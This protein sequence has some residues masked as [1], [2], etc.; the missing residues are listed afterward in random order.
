MNSEWSK[1]EIDACVRTYLWMRDSE[2][3]GYQPVKS[4]A[5]I[6]LRE[7]PLSERS[8][9]SLEYRFQN[10]SAV[11]ADRKEE[12]I[13]GYKPAKN[14]GAETASKIA[15]CIEAYGKVR[16]ARRVN[17]LMNALPKKTIVKAVTELASGKEFSYSD[18]TEYDLLYRGI[19]LP[20]KKVIG[21][22]AFLHYRAPLLSWNFSGGENTPCFKRLEGAGFTIV[23]KADS[24]T[25]NPEWTEFRKIVG[26]HKKTGFQSRPQGSRKPKKKSV[27]SIGYVRD[28]RVVAYVEERANGICELCNEPAPFNRPDGTP[29]LEVHHIIPL[30]DGGPDTVENAAAICPN[31]HRACHHGTDAIAHQDTLQ[32]TVSNKSV[33]ATATSA[34]PQL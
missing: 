32:T 16:H 25:V 31:C 6:A 9:G 30:A 2:A 21:Y 12:W 20:P 26:E 14:V 23:R 11:L 24:N 34:V 7:G 27:H 8:D 4:R 3:K 33:Q 15:A 22:A 28:A 19:P 5:R 10:I 18:S 13:E 17:W 29:F 1:S